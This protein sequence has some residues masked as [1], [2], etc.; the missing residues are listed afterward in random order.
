MGVLFSGREVIPGLAARY[1]Q[2]YLVPR[3]E[4][5]E[6]YRQITSQGKEPPAY[7][8]SHFVMND[9]DVCETVA[10]PAGEVMAV[11]LHERSDFETVLRCAGHDFSQKPYPATLGAQH[12][13]GLIDWPRIN[14]HKAAYERE[15]PDA[16]WLGWAMEFKRFR[17]NKR[18]YQSTLIVLSV[19][20][21]SAVPAQ[22]IGMEEG[23]WLRYSHEIRLYHECTHF[24]CRALYPEEID[25]VWDELV[26]DAAGL[27]AAFGRYD[28]ALAEIFLGIGENA[29]G[30]GRLIN[31]LTPEQMERKDALAARIHALLPR[32][33]D[34]AAPGQEPLQYALALEQKHRAWCHEIKI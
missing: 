34:L 4:N 23:E 22:R 5:E 28:P 19:G 8:L 31:Y 3:P 25:P 17:E 14:A 11:T 18:N 30:P 9:A 32:F 27:Y 2:L 7:D 26:A 13:S 16:G 12:I 33:A 6:A 20:P 21:Y 10:T 24:V 15:H 1:K 29:A